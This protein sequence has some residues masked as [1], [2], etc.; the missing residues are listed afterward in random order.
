MDDEESF[1]KIQYSILNLILVLICICFENLQAV[2][3]VLDLMGDKM[4]KWE[5]NP[6]SAC[7]CV[8]EVMIFL[9]L[10]RSQF[11]KKFTYRI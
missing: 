1:M 4:S 10:I 6:W 8:L 9:L 5:Q 2:T 11:N 7:D 3:Y